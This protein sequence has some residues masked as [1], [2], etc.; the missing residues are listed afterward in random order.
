MSHPFTNVLRV[1]LSMAVTWLMLGSLQ[2]QAPPATI[3]WGPQASEPSN[4]LVTKVVGI[5]PEGIYLL[6]QKILQSPSAR[7]RAW[8]E[9]AD[10]DMRVMRSEEL[11]LKYKGKQ[12]D[13]EDLILFG[14]GLYLFTSFNNTAHKKNYLFVQEVH[15]R[16]LQ[17]SRSLRMIAE[18]EARNK[19]VEGSFAFRLSEDSTHLLIFHDL[20]FEKR[21]PARFG[22]HVFDQ[23][24]QLV[25]EKEVTLPYPDNQFTVEEYRVDEQG[26][27]YLLGVLYEDEA[28]LRRRGQPTYKYIMLAYL[29]NG[30]RQEEFRFDL[31]ERFITD[32]T[33]R[34]ARSGELVFAGFYSEKG[35]YSIKG[36]YFFHLDPASRQVTN[37]QAAPFDFDFLTAFMSERSRA[38]ALEAERNNDIQRAPELFD[39]SLDRLILRSDGGAVLVA[40]QFY[41]ERETYRDYPYYSGFYY[42]YRFYDPFYYNRYNSL[43]TD[44]IYNYNDIIVVNIRPDGTLEWTAR[45]PKW[46][47]TRNDGGY[48]SSYVMS[49]VRDKLYFV[50]NDDPRNYDPRRNQRKVYKYTGGEAMMVLA[51]VNIKG[52]VH[53]YPLVD[54]GNSGVTLRPKVSRQIGLR[55]MLLFGEANRGYRLGK[56]RF[57]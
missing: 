51:E 16:S 11:D 36:S 28:K 30:E 13:F 6:R 9:Y 57:E 4:T 1:A 43:Q 14:D 7:P 53:F 39:Y 21:Q 52:E 42:P 50:Y 47:E 34:I 20:P 5:T 29:E 33:F 48:F 3:S 27:V 26:N 49:I 37:G 2:A 45:I 19:E 44:Y 10:R 12:R 40:E 38:K 8:V 41:V 54:A 56:L 46:Q 18:T 32:L 15:M 31:P 23:Q 24:M 35:T 22:F 55:E 25:W 17:A